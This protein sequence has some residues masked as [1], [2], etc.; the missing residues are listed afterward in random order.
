MP[1]QLSAAADR[2]ASVGPERV[3]TAIEVAGVAYRVR[4]RD[5]QALEILAPIDFQVRAGEFVALVGPS[6]SG[7]STLLNIISGLLSPSEGNVRIFGEPLRG[8]ARR[9]GYMFQT[10]ALLPW[11]SVL[12]NVQSGLELAG[13]PRREAARHAT[14]MLAQLGLS[15]FEHHYP[16]ELSGGMRQR[17]SLARTWVTNPDLLLMDEPFGALDSQTKLVIQSSFLSFWDKHRKTVVLV[18]HDIEEAI[19]MSDRVVV[20]SARPGRLKSEYAIDL[21]RP[22]SVIELRGEPRFTSYWKRI[23]H[24]L[25]LET[26]DAMQGRQR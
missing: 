23:W 26:E 10:D 24:D 6:G 21:P 8:T 9:I 25:E 1:A 4:G 12:R 15:G 3:E 7:K 11:R 13:V 5:G 17:V 14:E 19:A 16:A 20:M 22:R 18:T 2:G